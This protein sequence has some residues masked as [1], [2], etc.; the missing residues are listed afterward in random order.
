MLRDG[1]KTIPQWCGCKNKTTLKKN[2]D[3]INEYRRRKYAENQEAKNISL[4]ELSLILI[5]IMPLSFPAGAPPSSWSS[6][7][8]SWREQFGTRHDD[9]DAR[10]LLSKEPVTPRGEGEPWGTHGPGGVRS[11]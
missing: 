1:N 7:M 3:K 8:D 4:R 11:P 9:D 10:P 2:K 6:K 5:I